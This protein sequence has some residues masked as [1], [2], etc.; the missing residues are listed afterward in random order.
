LDALGVTCSVEKACDTAGLTRSAVY[1][2]RDEDADFKAAWEDVIG[3]IVG[4]A[5]AKMLQQARED[6]T[7]AGVSAR[8]IVLRA[9]MPEIYN[10]NLLLRREMLKLALDK[11]RA[12]ANSPPLIEGQAIRSDRTLAEL[13]PITVFAMPANLRA[14]SPHLPADFDEAE[15]RE[16]NPES[17]ALPFVAIKQDG[18]GMNRPLPAQVFVEYHDG[19]K[20][21]LV[22]SMLADGAEVA[23]EASTDLWARVKCYNNGL[24]MLLWSLNGATPP[25]HTEPVMLP[26]DDPELAIER[27]DGDDLR[28]GTEPTC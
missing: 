13:Q 14:T 15:W 12:E 6:E 8:N 22:A 1:R 24:G 20:P 10:P 26:P 7:P 16:D 18:S 23:P 21:E 11:A 9:Y 28:D 19:T 25:V 17:T 27:E 5:H 2:W 3:A 4:G